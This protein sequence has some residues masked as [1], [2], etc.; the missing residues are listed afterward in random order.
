MSEREKLSLYEFSSCPYCARVR[1]FL[2]ELGESVESR[3]VAGDRSHL[4]ELIRATGSQTVPCLRIEEPEGEVRWM[5]E[6]VDII[7]YLRD[8]FAGA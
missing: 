2:A 5:H 7:D 3:D 8:H 4:L 1:R 6:S